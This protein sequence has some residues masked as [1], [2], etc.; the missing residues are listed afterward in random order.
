M[1]PKEERG[2]LRAEQKKKEKKIGLTAL[3]HLGLSYLMGPRQAEGKLVALFF[4]FFIL[5]QSSPSDL[6]KKNAAISETKD[7]A[8]VSI[9]KHWHERPI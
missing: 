9:V 1:G 8:S 2:K 3:C 5:V 4:L 6:K 7:T